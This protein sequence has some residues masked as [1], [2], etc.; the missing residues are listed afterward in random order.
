MLKFCV[1]DRCLI[2]SLFQMP[3]RPLPNDR[4]SNLWRVCF[5]TSVPKTEWIGFRWIDTP[6]VRLGSRRSLRSAQLRMIEISAIRGSFVGR[7]VA[8]K[9]GFAHVN[10]ENSARSNCFFP[11]VRPKTRE[12][13]RDPRQQ[14]NTAVTAG[15]LYRPGLVLVTVNIQSPT[16]N[17]HSHSV[18]LIETLGDYRSAIKRWK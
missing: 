5:M 3:Q 7:L 17:C 4:F 18:T 8:R 9:V 2:E 16:K 12:I 15:P 11:V 6:L 1:S 14:A 13:Q 10:P